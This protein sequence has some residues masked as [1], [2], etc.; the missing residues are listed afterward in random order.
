ML[1]NASLRITIADTF[2]KRLVGLIGRRHLCADEALFIPRCRAVHTFFM[3]RP[4]DVIMLDKRNQVLR[5]I[6]SLPSWRVVCGDFRVVACL[7]LAAG[8][9]R[10][11]GIAPGLKLRC[12]QA[13]D[14]QILGR[15]V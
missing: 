3:R 9:S 14:G 7:E 2:L 4:I 12:E 13:G 5:V 1:M 11:F 8:T 15:M 10:A 6:E